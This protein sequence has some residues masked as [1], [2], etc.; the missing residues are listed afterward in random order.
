MNN[1][2]QFLL[3]LYHYTVLIRDTL[4][5]TYIKDKYD[6]NVYHA[7]KRALSHS[8]KEGGQVKLILSKIP[9]NGPKIEEK[10]NN[11]IEEIYSDKSTIL[12]L[13]SD[14][15]RVD[16]AQHLIIFEMVVG[17]HETMKDILYSYHQAAK[18]KGEVEI[19][20]DDLL[21]TDERMFRC[22]VFF[23]VMAEIEKAF[24]EF[25][26]V[27][28]ES[29]GEKTPQSNYIVGDLAKL[30]KLIMFQKAKSRIKD[31]SFN[32]MMDTNIRVLEMI[33]GKRE[34]P[35]KVV[36]DEDTEEAKRGVK[37]NG[38]LHKPFGEVFSEAR[39][40]TRAILGE[41]E[42][43]WKEIYRPINEQLEKLRLAKDNEKDKKHMDA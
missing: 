25:Q 28:R 31:T 3:S 42:R 15:L 2:T 18:Q 41:S 21:K 20:L 29:K 38:V 22:I 24:G 33:E 19:S 26:K 37:I 14:E 13:T 36:H 11:F 1:A 6:V 8:L 5:Y 12:K 23:T 39:E 43:E 27:M 30:S 40:V 7:R 35:I 10:L 34:L 4:E 32:D 17:L 16:H 9:E